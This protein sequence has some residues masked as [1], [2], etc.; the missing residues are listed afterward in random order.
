M[1]QE[2]TRD[3]CPRERALSRTATPSH[4]HPQST[5]HLTQIFLDPG[6]KYQ[7]ILYTFDYFKHMDEYEDRIQ[8]DSVFVE[9]C[10]SCRN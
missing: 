10:R 7:N 4:I 6:K 9:V 1:P 2:P 3:R 8:K 5:L